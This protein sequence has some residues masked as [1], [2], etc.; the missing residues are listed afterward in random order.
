MISTA[1][2]IQQPAID[3]A[4]FLSMTTQ[5]LGYSPGAAA[6]ANMRLLHDAEKFMS[7]LAAMKD[8]RAPVGL[9]PHL[10]T[11]V[12]FSVLVI[13][14]ERDMQDV[15]EYCS[16]MPF[17]ITDT[18]ARSIQAAVITG[19]LDNWRTAVISGCH[20]NVV[21]PVRALFNRILSLFEQVNLNVWKDCDRKQEGQTFLLED[22]RG[23]K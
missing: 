13:A 12:S 22:H 3:F 7:C 17:V 14:D 2:L 19:T 16:G 9:S 11:H 4:T 18:V 5:A 21:P 1:I 10:L 6:D 20:H 15:L 8:E 23:S